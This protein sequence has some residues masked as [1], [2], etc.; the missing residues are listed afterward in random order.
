MGEKVLIAGPGLANPFMDASELSL[1][2][3]DRGRIALANGYASHGETVRRVRDRTGDVTEV[4]LGGTRFLRESAI[5]E[6][7]E[8]RYA[9]R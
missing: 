4:W 9:R 3:R 5:A 8:A 6:E 7:L 2:A 1:S